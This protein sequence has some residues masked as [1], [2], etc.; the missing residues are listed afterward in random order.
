MSARPQY[1]VPEGWPQYRA[2]IDRALDRGWLT[3]HESGTYV[4]FTE[5]GAALF[6]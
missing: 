6:A 4:R 2:G 3:R 5:A 1:A